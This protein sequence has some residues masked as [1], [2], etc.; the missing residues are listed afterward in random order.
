MSAHTVP[1]QAHGRQPAHERAGADPSSAARRMRELVAARSPGRR[2]VIKIGRDDA[3]NP[4]PFWLASFVFY[5]PPKIIAASVG[6]YEG[7]PVV[8]DSGRA[9]HRDGSH[10]FPLSDEQAEAAADKAR[11]RDSFAQPV[12][13]AQPRR[14]QGRA[15]AIRL[16]AD[17]PAAGRR[18]ALR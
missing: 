18:A 11:L 3:R 4:A 8:R 13:L 2:Q 10:R 16:L 12:R 1:S 7:S 14:P 17:D 5:G 6:A 15:R 9:I